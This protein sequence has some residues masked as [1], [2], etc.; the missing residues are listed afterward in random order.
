MF[1][2]GGFW[3]FTGGLTQVETFYRQLPTL[4]CG[5]GIPPAGSHQPTGGKSILRF[6]VRSESVQS[7][8]ANPRTAGR[9]RFH[10]DRSQVG[11]LVSDL[12]ATFLLL[13]PPIIVAIHVIF[14][15][16]FRLFG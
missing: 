11:P 15:E 7:L 5:L 3:Q 2:S 10:C 6:W 9:V 12:Q 4:R 16:F 14:H 8:Q 13:K 1:S